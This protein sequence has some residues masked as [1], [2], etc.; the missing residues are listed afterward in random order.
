MFILNPTRSV[1]GPTYLNK[2]EPLVENKSEHDARNDHKHVAEGV[3]L[4]VVC[5]LVLVSH[6][7]YEPICRGKEYDFHDGVVSRGEVPEDIKVTGGEYDGIKLLGLEG[8]S[9]N[10]VVSIRGVVVSGCDIRKYS[11]VAG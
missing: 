10:K 9:C 8:N 7:V 5:V 1:K 3:V 2:L 4:F 11:G 6:D